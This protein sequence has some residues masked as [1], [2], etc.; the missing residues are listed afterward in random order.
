MV[1]LTVLWQKQNISKNLVPKGQVSRDLYLSLNGNKD[2]LI[3][4]W[5]FHCLQ[6][7]GPLNPEQSFWTQG[8]QLFF[9]KE[10]FL[11]RSVKNLLMSYLPDSTESHLEATA[12]LNLLIVPSFAPTILLVLCLCPLAL[13][14]PP[15][16]IF[17]TKFLAAWNFLLHLIP[18]QPRTCLHHPTRHY[19]QWL[20]HLP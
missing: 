10:H 1:L 18:G 8:L 11:P 9:G 4:G 17:F 12:I 13:C 3:T 20:L 7:K 5:W 15:P 19:I 14:K 2:V 6:I 16:P